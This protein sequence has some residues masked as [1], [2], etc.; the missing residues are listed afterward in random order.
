MSKLT[1]HIAFA[2]PN[3]KNRV[4]L[5][6][7]DDAHQSDRRIVKIFNENNLKATFHVNSHLLDDVD[8]R[9]NSTDLLEVYA[10]HEIACHGA[11]HVEHSIIPQEVLISELIENRK[12][13]EEITKRPVRG[14]SYPFGTYSKN[15][16]RTAENLGFAYGRGI[17]TDQSMVVPDNFFSTSF[18]HGY[19]LHH[20]DLTL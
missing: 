15:I 19:Q 18:F 6:S 10:G 1:K 17:E 8:V 20:Q 2:F 3:W 13:L 14:L 7:Y 5:L 12:M 16:A 4:F 9:L 11:R